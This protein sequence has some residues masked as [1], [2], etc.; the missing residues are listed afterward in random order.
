MLTLAFEHLHAVAAVTAAFEDNRAAGVVSRGV[1]YEE[2]GLEVADRDGQRVPAT[3]F[4]LT[5]NLD[6]KRTWRIGGDEVRR[7]AAP[8]TSPRRPR[9][10]ASG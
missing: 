2:D 9:S 7:A 8:S 3:R 1:G 5:A 6:A 4:R 10:C